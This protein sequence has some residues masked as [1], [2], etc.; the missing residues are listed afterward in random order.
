MST[1]QPAEPP[2]PKK[3][4]R[5]T[6]RRLVAVG[7]VLALVGVVLGLIAQRT[8]LSASDPPEKTYQ[9]IFAAYGGQEALD[10]WWCGELKYESSFETSR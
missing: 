7:A 4:H 8:T 9:K 10:R 3:S 1:E 5:R 2:K 6:L